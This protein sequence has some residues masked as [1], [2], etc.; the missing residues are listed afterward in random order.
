MKI[1]STQKLFSQFKKE[2]FFK[3]TLFVFEDDTEL[4]LNSENKVI[5]FSSSNPNVD[6]YL[7]QLK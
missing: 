5:D 3:G 4:I 7:K 6:F 1:L 2:T